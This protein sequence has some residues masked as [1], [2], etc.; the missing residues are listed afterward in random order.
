MITPNE[1]K[2][3][4]E[5]YFYRYFSIPSYDEIPLEKRLGKKE[6]LE[7]YTSTLTKDR[8]ARLIGEIEKLDPYFTR[9]DIISLIKKE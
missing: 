4:L 6:F 7:K 2:E 8:D 3:M 1:E 5:D 9:K